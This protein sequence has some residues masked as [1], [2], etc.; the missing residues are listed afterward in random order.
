MPLAVQKLTSHPSARIRLA[1]YKREE[2]FSPDEECQLIIQAQKGDN[3]A[4]TQIHDKYFPK[5]KEYAKKHYGKLRMNPGDIEEAG[6]LKIYDCIRSFNPG[7]HERLGPLLFVSLKNYLR[8]ITRRR[9]RVIVH[10]IDAEL[11]EETTYQDLFADP[12]SMPKSKHDLSH[13][14]EILCDPEGNYLRDILTTSELAVIEL[15]LSDRESTPSS[16][17]RQIG[18]SRS[19]VAWKLKNAQAK[20]KEAI[21]IIDERGT[22]TPEDKARIRQI[23]CPYINSRKK[24]S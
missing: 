5:I 20:M 6:N 13:S 1:Y 24:I 8:D 14:L 15:L 22:L 9:D 3:D 10:S 21:E 23:K 17:G 7:K 18:L 4:C 11:S 2:E 16:I 19:T 12:H